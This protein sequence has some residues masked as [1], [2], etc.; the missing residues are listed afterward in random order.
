MPMSIEEI[1]EKI[2][3]KHLGNPQRHGLAELHLMELERALAGLASIGEN[4]GLEFGVTPAAV[5]FPKMLYHAK[6]MQPR[7][8]ESSEEET[9]ARGQG[10]NE[11][12]G[13]VPPSGEVKMPGVANPAPAPI[14]A[15]TTKV[16]VPV[17]GNTKRS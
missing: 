16:S 3:G 1:R 13:G 4:I 6:E 12:P 8:I 15:P 9:E 5:Q 7:I 17:A 11:F 10:W 2:L 14:P